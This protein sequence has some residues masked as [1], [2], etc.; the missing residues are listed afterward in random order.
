MRLYSV[1]LLLILI[2]LLAAIGSPTAA[3]VTTLTPRVYL[4]ITATPTPYGLPILLVTPATGCAAPLPLTVGG[5]VLL[6]GGV[7]VRS[8]PSLSAP[9]VN[10]YPNQVQL[11]LIGGPTC[12]NGYNWWHVSGI[13]EPGWVVEGMPGVYY[14]QGYNPVPTSAC[15]PAL[16]TILVGGQLRTITGSRVRQLPG[17]DQFV[18]TVLPANTTVTVTA[19]PVCADT[20]NWWQI[21]APY[22][23]SGANILG[24]IEEG[25]PTNYFIEVVG[26]P[27]TPLPCRAPLRLSAGSEVAV[28]YK[29]GVPRHLR[30]AP[31]VSSPV[32]ANLLD[33][34]ALDVINNNSVCADAYNWWQVR[35][36]STG[37]TGWIAE[38]RPGNYWFE[39]LVK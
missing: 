3:Q 36:V 28:T 1:L 8:Q 7:F 20:G 24:W 22:G 32:V 39:V 11:H 19:G 10:Y 4:Q 16:D 17:S 6:R 29:D 37:I 12:A 35:I 21:L 27:P 26:V 38:G 23:N 13:G 33:G 18:L 15:A 34:I 5:Q 14:L 30:S 9:Q 31:S 2:V 25:Y